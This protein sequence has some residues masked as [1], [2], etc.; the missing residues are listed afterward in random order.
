M[1][2]FEENVRQCVLQMETLEKWSVEKTQST[3]RALLDALWWWSVGEHF[4]VEVPRQDAISVGDIE[5]FEDQER[6]VWRKLPI[7]TNI[8]LAKPPEYYITARRLRAG[9]WEYVTGTRLNGLTRRDN[10]YSSHLLCCSICV[11]GPLTVSPVKT[12]VL[13]PESVV[14]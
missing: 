12:W 13:E 3:A 5:W 10:P 8:Q 4:G 11:G 9:E 7:F 6:P 14:A 2:S 1:W